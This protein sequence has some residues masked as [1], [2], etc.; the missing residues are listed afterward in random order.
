MNSDSSDAIMAY[1]LQ[2]Y[3][4]ITIFVK[5]NRCMLE[6]FR[7]KVFV[8][9]AQEKSFTKA[10]EKL[11]IS[12]PA[13]SQNVAELER[14]TGQKLFERLR[15]E[16][17]LTVAGDVFAGYA[18]KILAAAAEADLMFSEP[19]ISSVRISASEEV[20]SGIILPA[21]KGFMAVHPEVSVELSSSDDCDILA[22]LM[23][24]AAGAHSSFE[25]VYKPTQAF[26][27]T[28]TCMVLKNILGF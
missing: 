14:M 10:A 3:V 9:V 15:G 19:D 4:K 12:Q 25:L 27:F 21:L 2:R 17:V 23:P 18:Q 28:K 13:V 6:D 7:L 1:K 5:N 11:G 16:T 22:V 8:A 24:S 26:A 20:F